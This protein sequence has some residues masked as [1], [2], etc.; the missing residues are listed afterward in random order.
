VDLTS[1]TE[2]LRWTHPY[3]LRRHRRRFAAHVDACWREAAALG[4]VGALNVIE[5][6]AETLRAGRSV[7]IDD[8]L[9]EEIRERTP[10]SLHGSGAGDAIDNRMITGVWCTPE[11]IKPR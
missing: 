5:R 9:P 10:T 7:R 6:L 4:L 1:L 3:V 11:C 8:V 2:L